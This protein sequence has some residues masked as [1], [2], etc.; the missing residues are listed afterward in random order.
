MPREYTPQ[1][2]AVLADAK[3][4][5]VQKAITARAI[6][7]RRKAG[8]RLL[9]PEGVYTI[10]IATSAPAKWKIPYGEI[11]HVVM[12]YIGR[13]P[14][15]GARLALDAAGNW[16]LDAGVV[17]DVASRMALYDR[18]RDELVVQDPNILGGT[19]VIKGT[20]LNVYAIAGRLAQGETLE[21]ILREYPYVTREQIEAAA[22]YAKANPLR[23]RP[24][25]RP[26]EKRRKSRSS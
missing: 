16:T 17:R 24:G 12:K 5:A 21:E 23:G 26:W 7:V 3:L 6:P 20:R 11:R 14:A 22:L 25:G 2:A 9:K 8:R 18:A 19:P 13:M 15:A 1:E 4:G 10:A